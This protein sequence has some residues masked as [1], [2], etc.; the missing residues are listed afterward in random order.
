VDLG[1]SSGRVI[2]ARVGPGSLSISEVKRFANGPVRLGSS[3]RW[4]VQALLQGM[5]Q[6][7]R[8]AELE[9]GQLDGAA[10]DTWAMDYGALDSGGALL[11]DPFCYRDQRTVGV[12]GK[13]QALVTREELYDRTGIQFLSFNT[14]YQLMAEAGSQQ[15]EVTDRVLLMPDLLGYLLTGVQF[16][17]ITNASTTQLL[18]ARSGE[19]ATDLAKQVSIPPGWFPPLRRSGEWLGQ[20]RPSVLAEAGLAGPVPL[21]TVASHDT[22]SAV[23]A[24]PASD[25]RFAFISC[26]TWSLVGVELERPMIT[27]DSLRLNFTNEV[28]VDGTIRFL[29]NVMG[30]WLLQECIRAWQGAGLKTDLES[31]VCGAAAEPPLRT[32]FDPDNLGLLMPGNMPSRIATVCRE[33][34]QPVPQTQTA[35]VR[36]II[37]SLSMAHRRTLRAA[38]SLCGR[39]VTTI[40]LV[41]GG[42]RNELLCQL[43]A[44]ACGLPVVAGPVEAAAI[45]NVLIQARALG[46]LGGGLFDLRGLVRQTQVLRRYEPRDQDSDWDRA[47]KGAPWGVGAPWSGS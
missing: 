17:E 28:G 7:L 29:R 21:F 35:M 12:M 1:A 45:G 19:W 27:S 37:E 10:I 15:G 38:L 3:L 11:A 44:D 24:T 36:A 6:G 32:L 9:L 16:A 34:G 47:E 4:D 31:L 25:E 20:V 8:L 13:A 26:G 2:A 14:I 39:D 40:H 23:V 42:A 41:G 30:L 22:A 5:L 46:V 33:S 18:D 43:T